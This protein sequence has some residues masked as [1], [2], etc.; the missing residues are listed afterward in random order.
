MEKQKTAVIANVW[1]EKHAM[2]CKPVLLKYQTNK[3]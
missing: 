1:R 2:D 3:K